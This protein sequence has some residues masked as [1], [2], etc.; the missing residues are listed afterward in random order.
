MQFPPGMGKTTIKAY[1]EAAIMTA[2]Y[3]YD[4]EQTI[5]SKDLSLYKYKS[6]KWAGDLMFAN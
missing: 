1:D 6:N 3:D 2:S 4:S 5:G